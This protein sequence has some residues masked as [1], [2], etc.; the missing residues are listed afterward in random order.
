MKKR[1]F[2]KKIA[3]LLSA[4]M[5]FA[6]L[7]PA[8]PAYAADTK[9]IFDFKTNNEAIAGIVNNW[10]YSGP[11]GSE[12]RFKLPGGWSTKTTSTSTP[13][14]PNAP[15]IVGLPYWNS[16]DI[17]G[18]ND[19]FSETVNNA[20][21]AWN[22]ASGMDLKGY[23][24]NLW[25]NGKV[26]A[27][28]VERVE[29]P[30]F[31]RALHG[32][33]G[34][35]TYYATIG[36]NGSPVASY[37]V[38]RQGKGG[39]YVP[40][41]KD[42]LA[43]PFKAGAS[44]A[45]KAD[46]APGYMLL[47]EDKDNSGVIG[48]QTIEILNSQSTTAG[49][50][51]P[52]DRTP[53][54]DADK[55]T[56][57][58]DKS[59]RTTTKYAHNRDVIVNYRYDVDAA[60][61][62]DVNVWDVFFDS[63]GHEIS[64]SK[65]TKLS[66]EVLGD[67]GAAVGFDDAK[68]TGSPAR[69]VKMDAGGT[70]VKYFYP[71]GA[72][73]TYTT[74]VT[75]VF[76]KEKNGAGSAPEGDFA[77]ANMVD[78]NIDVTGGKTFHIDSNDKIAGKM[79]NQKVDV[80]YNYK[81]N[82]A[83]YTNITVQYVDENGTSIN[84]KVIAATKASGYPASAPKI[85]DAYD[86]GNVTAVYKNGNEIMAKVDSHLGTNEVQIPVPK[87]TGYKFNLG[88][89]TIEA[90]DANKWNLNYGPQPPVIDPIAVGSNYTVAKVRQLGSASESAVLRITYPMEAAELV[91]IIPE[92]G[93]GGELKVANASGVL[94]PY[95]PS[96]H[97]SHQKYVAKAPGGSATTN[98]VTI[99]VD[100]LPEPVPSAGYLFDKWVYAAANIEFTQSD[101]PK[102]FEI[103][104]SSNASMKFKAIFKKDPS[105]Y[106]TYHLES[107]DGYTQIVGDPNPSVLNVD[108]SGNPVDVRFSDLSS[109]TGVG[110]GI[111]LN[112]HPF[113]TNYNVVWYS[114]NNV[115]L[116]LDASG[117]VIE[118]DNRAIVHDETFRVYVES[119]A[120]ATAYD[121]QLENGIGGT[122]ELLNSVTGE[123]QIALDATNP[124]PMSSSVNY[125]VTDETGKVVQ[126]IPGTDLKQHGGVITNTPTSN[127]L[128]PGNKYKVYTALKSAGAVVGA[129]IPA[130]DVSGH[131]LEV[132][133]PVAPTP[134]VTA[135]SANPG[136]AMIK[137]NPTADNTEY[138]LVDDDGNEVYPFTTPTA[139]DNGTI[140]FRNLDPDTVYHVVP[141]AAGSGT[142]IADRM[143]AGAQLP[144]DTSNM[145]L[146]VSKF[147]VEVTTTHPGT[148]VIS[149]L[150]YD[151]DN[152]AAADF[153]AT[154][155]SM[156][157]GKSVEIVAP[158][159]DGLSNDYYTW[160][161]VSPSGL[162]VSQGTGG[163]PL[164]PANTRIVFT[165]P[166]GPVKLQIMYN[167][168]VTWDPDNWT[169]NNISNKNIGV[170]VPNIA[171]PS[172]SQMRITVKK[173]TVPANI[174]QIVADTL[175]DKYSAEYMFRIAVEKKDGSGNWV[176]YTDP[177]GD[178]SL[179]DVRV[180]TGAL[181]FS[182]NYML[183]ELATS[184]NAASLVKENIGRLSSTSADPN[185]PGEFSQNMYAG[186]VYVFGYSKPIA[187]KVKI[188]DNSNNKLV[189]SLNVPENHTVNDFSAQYS[190][191]VKADNPDKDGI[192]WKY[193]GLST[194][195]NSYVEYDANTRVTQDM[196]I[197]MFHSNDRDA[198]KKADNDLKSGI[199]NAKDQLSKIT[200]PVKKAALQ[201]AIDA[202]Q[203]VL[204]RT[205]PRKASTPE[206][207]AALD[208][209]NQA[210]RDAGGKPY[211]PDN[212]NHRGGGGGGGGGKAGKKAAN[213]NALRVGYDGNWELLNPEEK[214]LD[215]SKWVFNLTS[216][217]RVTGWA[218]LSYTYEGQTRSEWYHF[219]TDNVM[220]TGWF[221]DGAT[222]RWYYLSMDH[223]GFYG[224]MLKG[225]YHDGA[226]GRWY[227]L[228]PSN[229]S[230]QTGWVKVDSDYYYL[231]PNAPEQT[232]FFDAN[233]VRWHYG[234]GTGRPLG[235]MYRNESTPGG[236]NVNE[237]GAWR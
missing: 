91:K 64:K 198:R 195:K 101:L 62:F 24:I 235:S 92:Y 173:D 56:L 38:T 67:L 97:A 121:P 88:D 146:G 148:Q 99:T 59:K 145:G 63:S 69:Y 58:Y 206:L 20:A 126:V 33:S 116:K 103:P 45:A 110:T 73:P 215:N 117:N 159:I 106:N 78:A 94:E 57:K 83:Y 192:T 182:R 226:D 170:T 237:S 93:A 205:S 225:W 34:D 156:E 151:G 190:S 176:E 77:A 21:K 28:K 109:Y 122:P 8:M 214:N 46:I 79:L 118:Q 133:I 16:K 98:K 164:S 119:D 1:N 168:G 39:V 172:G 61:K 200:D 162:T 70:G 7:A 96:T 223:N 47:N 204:S 135:D 53:Y 55:V 169:G 5:A 66:K 41:V 218:Y 186:K 32:N 142:S 52:T 202:A 68:L 140:E 13:P 224:E 132:T 160:R 221:F 42:D 178:I 51:L 231:N 191:Y 166:N 129:P 152:I 2:K 229:G 3:V 130:N 211:I 184:S 153:D 50:A 175:T 131:P 23:K 87:L 90:L 29:Q 125:V 18:G 157:K 201:A 120:P 194:D 112:S 203:A 181:D 12:F 76:S 213:N 196:T 115:I 25:K 9:L 138:A 137:I 80:Y 147:K 49:A 161:V 183:H 113:G 123:P 207:I 54:A 4:S 167:D 139:A 89:I 179:D 236:Y 143:A 127:F 14:D 71:G 189:A 86:I 65:R 212:N 228:N 6:M 26:D 10:E 180:N 108:G 227:Y 217:G 37:W 149:A 31:Q 188:V 141:R 22:E 187:Y 43:T 154:L 216:G 197:Y 17:N 105:R 107:G 48:V 150:K 85:L 124:S 134:L 30:Y 75:V 165:M 232:W 72:V 44:I 82:P 100:D 27:I 84:D 36:D 35:T 19:G 155:S 174:K 144:V 222:D 15:H 177:S 40:G 128:T 233:T 219:G 111:I 185:Y 81:I 209:L 74:P 158:L 210:V 171:V 234:N 193:E 102:E 11:E 230:M 95:E 163:T 208:A 220:N 199:Q 114:G 136:K 104:A 60:Q